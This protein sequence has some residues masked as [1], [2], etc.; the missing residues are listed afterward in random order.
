M[1]PSERDQLANIK[2]HSKKLLNADRAY[3]LSG[4]HF[5][6]FFEYLERISYP[7]EVDFDSCRSNGCFPS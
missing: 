4:D 3:L 2:L 5:S 7:N 1:T 6:V